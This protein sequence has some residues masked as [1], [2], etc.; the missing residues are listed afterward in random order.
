MRATI[1]PMATILTKA[2]VSVMAKGCIVASLV[3]FL[4]LL[5]TYINVYAIIIYYDN[6]HI[7]TREKHC[8]RNTPNPQYSPL[9][10]SGS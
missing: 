3:F 10:T 7:L 1:L 9:L 8:N 5:P 2:A 4:F 6:S